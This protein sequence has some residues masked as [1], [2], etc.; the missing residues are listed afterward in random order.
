M[1]LDS[2][3]QAFQGFELEIFQGGKLLNRPTYFPSSFAGLGTTYLFDF[4]FFELGPNA[5]DFILATLGE[6]PIFV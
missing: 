1:L 3:S 6:T 2:D 4:S 5:F